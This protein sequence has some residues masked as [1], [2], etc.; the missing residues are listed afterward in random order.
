M[1]HQDKDVLD[2]TVTLRLEPS[3]RIGEVEARRELLLRQLDGREPVRIDV[4]ALQSVDTAGV[5]LLLAFRQEADRRGIRV[6]YC[7]ESPEL[8]NALQVLG[9]TDAV[10]GRRP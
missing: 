6:D 7:G 9:L 2:D 8:V 4:G 10:F 5:Q 3:L 1:E